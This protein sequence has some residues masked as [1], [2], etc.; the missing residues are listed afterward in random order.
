MNLTLGAAYTTVTFSDDERSL[1]YRWLCDLLTIDTDPDGKRTSFLHRQGYKHVKRYELFLEAQGSDYKFPTGLVGYVLDAAYEKGFNTTIS[2]AAG[3]AKL[4]I[5]VQPSGLVTPKGMSVRDYQ[6]DLIT[7]AAT[8]GRGIIKAATAAGKTAIMGLLLQT[9]GNP[10]SL[11]MVGSRSLVRQTR[12][13]VSRWLNAPVGE[14]SSGEVDLSPNCVVGMVQSMAAHSSSPVFQELLRTRKVLL[15]D[16]VHHCCVSGKSSA[17]GKISGG[18]WF[19][20]MMA[21]PAANRY[22][23]SATPLKVSEPA[24]NWRVIGATGPLFK[25]SISSSQLIGEGFAATPYCIFLPFKS[26][27]IS[28]SVNYREAVNSGIVHCDARNQLI[29]DS[30][31][32]LA[33]NGLKTMILVEHVEHGDLLYSMLNVQSPHGIL[34]EYINGTMGQ[35]Q[36]EDKLRW[37]REDGARIIVTTRVLGEGTNVPDIGGVVYAKGGKSFVQLFQCIGRGQ[38]PKGADGGFCIIVIPDDAHNARY[39]KK[40]NKMLRTYLASEP[41]YRI[42]EGKQSLDWFIESV[43]EGRAAINEPSAKDDS[44]GEASEA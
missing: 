38:R 3:A 17:K 21:C 42:A 16:E 32:T 20:I 18:A 35:S 33:E 12:Q 14:F 4:P 10:P 44:D 30:A 11:I 7:E 37:L 15:A 5:V 27:V 40:H 19:A 39:L 23:L 9:L 25:H 28:S 8:K 43:V 29:V 31:V 2:W 36:Q 13:E 22:G 34:V 1:S 41:A 26:P 24:Q 6:L